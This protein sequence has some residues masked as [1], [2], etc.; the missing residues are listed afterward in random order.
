[1]GCKTST[2]RP[3]PLNTSPKDRPTLQSHS[4]GAGG[5]ALAAQA[6]DVLLLSDSLS[7]L[8]VLLRLAR[9]YRCVVQWNIALAVAL[10]AVMLGLNFVILLPLWTAVVSDMVALVLVIASGLTLLAPLKTSKA[11]IDRHYDYN[12]LIES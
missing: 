3:R 4:A 5:T 9:R 7:L 6:A 10:K 2:G 1:M 12:K 11:V 8:P